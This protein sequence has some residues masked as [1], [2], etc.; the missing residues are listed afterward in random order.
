MGAIIKWV[1]GIILIFG[2][3]VLFGS[4]W[5]DAGACIGLIISIIIIYVISEYENG[6]SIDKTTKEISNEY[7][8]GQ[9]IS[10]HV[11]GVSF[12]NRQSMVKNLNIGDYLRVY[13]DY[14]N[15][16][17]ENA[18]GVFLHSNDEIVGYIPRELACKIAQFFDK[19]DYSPAYIVSVNAK[20]IEK[21]I[22]RDKIIGI[23]I[24]FTV[25]TQYD[26]DSSRIEA[27]LWDIY[28]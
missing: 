24:T 10:T 28:Y 12:N 16:F 11:A 20:V 14:E 21:N 17:D 15:K 27:D 25:P 19:F 9:E 18:I 7:F 13:R 8:P 23:R 5:G 22:N 2:S 1:F 3:I 4:L 26:S 6:N